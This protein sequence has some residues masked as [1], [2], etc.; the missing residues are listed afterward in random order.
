ML[1]GR[2]VPSASTIVW[3]RIPS[4]RLIL[5]PAA[6]VH[7]RHR[8]FGSRAGRNRHLIAH[9]H[10]ARHARLHRIFNFRAI[11]GDGRFDLQ[12]R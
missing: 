3:N 5:Q 1:I 6:L 9:L 12:A 10:V 2:R 4:L 11:A 7:Q 8:T